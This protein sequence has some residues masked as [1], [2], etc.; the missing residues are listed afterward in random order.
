[1]GLLQEAAS[2][3]GGPVRGVL[4]VKNREAAAGIQL[5]RSV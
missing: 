4:G 3:L 5:D 1:M 2:L